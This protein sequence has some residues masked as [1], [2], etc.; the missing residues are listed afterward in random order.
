MICLIVP[1]S[2]FLQAELASLASKLSRLVFLLHV[3][4][5][6]LLCYF[7]RSGADKSI[8][9]KVEMFGCRFLDGSIGR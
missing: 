4:C 2:P 7:S 9:K 8:R 6:N 3:Q 5:L 1:N